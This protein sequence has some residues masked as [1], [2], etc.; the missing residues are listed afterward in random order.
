MRAWS[1]LLDLRS[2]IA[3]IFFLKAPIPSS[4][5]REYGN[6]PSSTE[7]RSFECCS[8]LWVST[9]ALRWVSRAGK[10]TGANRTDDVEGLLDVLDGPDR[11]NNGSPAGFLSQPG[12]GLCSVPWCRLVEPSGSDVGE[13]A[14]PW[15]DP[16]YSPCD[17]VSAYFSS[18]E[19]GI[20]VLLSAALQSPFAGGTWS[21]VLAGDSGWLSESDRELLACCER[22]RA[23]RMTGSMKR[24]VMSPLMEGR[25]Q[26][27]TGTERSGIQR[28]RRKLRISS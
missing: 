19:S 20:M 16:A 13:I 26:H 27:L 10:A 12:E 15:S 21:R 1:A 11:R 22:R 9:L 23:C 14:R 25:W 8:G 7:I 6:P 3:W 18:G 24:E 17:G 5:G 2:L 4:S 28:G